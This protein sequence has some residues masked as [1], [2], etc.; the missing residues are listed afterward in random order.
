M[1]GSA[2]LVSFFFPLPVA[3]FGAIRNVMGRFLRMHS[4]DEGLMF[5]QGDSIEK[6][7]VKRSKLL[8]EAA[9]VIQSVKA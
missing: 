2:A 4:G 8:K 3:L 7:I 5:K 1:V 6:F 9:Q